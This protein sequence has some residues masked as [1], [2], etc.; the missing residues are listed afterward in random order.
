MMIVATNF[1]LVLNPLVGVSKHSSNHCHRSIYLGCYQRISWLQ[2]VQKL[3][4]LAS[5]RRLAV[6]VWSAYPI[7]SSVSV[8]SFP[9]RT[10]V[11][12]FSFW[13]PCTGVRTSTWWCTADRSRDIADHGILPLDF[14]GVWIL[15]R[16]GIAVVNMILGDGSIMNIK[17]IEIQIRI[18]FDSNHSM[19]PQFLGV[20]KCHVLIRTLTIL[21]RNWD[22]VEC[23]IRCRWFSAL[24]WSKF[25]PPSTQVRPDLYTESVNDWSLA[26][27]I[28]NSSQIPSCN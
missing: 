4:L 14:A 10:K 8:Y 23:W 18:P 26:F 13:E 6:P 3:S 15:Q 7:K 16:Y 27:N 21:V 24:V 20:I 1:H 25:V 17:T 19:L 9:I 5:E 11:R 28:G 2:G 12:W 22:R